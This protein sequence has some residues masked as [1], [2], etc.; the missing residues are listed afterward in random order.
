MLRKKILVKGA[1]REYAEKGKYKGKSNGNNHHIVLPRSSINET[2][3]LY[4]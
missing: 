2:Y 3:I 1:T 4:I